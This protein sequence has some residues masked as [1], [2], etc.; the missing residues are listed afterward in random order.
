M[1]CNDVHRDGQQTWQW[2]TVLTD[3]QVN[4]HCF[5]RLV[6]LC[7]IVRD[8]RRQH[9]RGKEADF[10]EGNNSSL[11]TKSV[12]IFLT[13][14]FLATVKLA[15]HLHQGVWEFHSLRESTWYSL[16]AAASGCARTRW[17]VGSQRERRKRCSRRNIWVA[18]SGLSWS[19][20]RWAPIEYAGKKKEDTKT[21]RIFQVWKSVEAYSTSQWNPNN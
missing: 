9:N 15:P 14:T 10:K 13:C 11:K 6:C 7:D 5:E 16:H 18:A 2:T 8:T 4:K 19:E 17:S 3:L 21:S 20:S 1:H 12:Y